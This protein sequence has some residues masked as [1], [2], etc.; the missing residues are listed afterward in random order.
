MPYQQFPIRGTLMDT[1]K[2]NFWHTLPGIL[3]ASATLLTAVTGFYLALRPNN[4]ETADSVTGYEASVLGTPTDSSQRKAAEPAAPAAAWTAWPIIGRD[5]FDASSGWQDWDMGS[6]ESYS[7][8]VTQWIDGAYRYD[9]DT[10]VNWWSYVRSP[11]GSL[12]DLYVEVDA[13]IVDHT[14]GVEAVVGLVFGNTANS[15]Y[16]VLVTTNGSLALTRRDPASHDDLL[17][18]QNVRVDPANPMKLGVLV[19][20]DLIQVYLNGKLMSEVRDDRYRGGQVALSAGVSAAGRVVAVF[21]NF[22]LRR[23]PR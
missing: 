14:P 4:S 9:I 15:N 10:R 2:P 1:G 18:W 13:R 16:Y 3:T 7:R 19:E 6:N 23:K 8:F 17:P 20:G 22:E 12:T 21:D 5:D 11:Y